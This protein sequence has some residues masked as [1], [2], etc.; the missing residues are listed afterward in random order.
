MI[1]TQ[2]S[3]LFLADW[4]AAC[5]TLYSAMPELDDS[6]WPM[7]I[8]VQKMTKSQPPFKTHIL[9]SRAMLSNTHMW[10]LKFKLIKIKNPGPQSHRYILK[11]KDPCVASCF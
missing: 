3:K 5:L 2:K 1:Q 6:I 10:L 7:D 4:M 11:N 8:L 9:K